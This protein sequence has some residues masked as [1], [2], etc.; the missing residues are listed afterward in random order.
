MEYWEHRKNEWRQLI[1]E[2]WAAQTDDSE[3][4]QVLHVLNN[5][6]RGKWKKKRENTATPTRSAATTHPT[7][8]PCKI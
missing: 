8:I 5:K 4:L 1:L 6:R 2:N 7:S 3:N